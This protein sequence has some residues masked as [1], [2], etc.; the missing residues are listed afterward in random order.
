MSDEYRLKCCG[1][2]ISRFRHEDEGKYREWCRHT[3]K[4]SPSSN[5]CDKWAWDFMTEADRM[6]KN[7]N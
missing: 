5:V 6:G 1:N 3:K 7:E 4:C 2:C